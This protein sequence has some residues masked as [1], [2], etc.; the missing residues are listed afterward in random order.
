MRS[1]VHTLALSGIGNDKYTITALYWRMGHNF[2]EAWDSY[3][4]RYDEYKVNFIVRR[5]WRANSPNNRTGDNSNNIGASRATFWAYYDPD[6][7]TAPADNFKFWFHGTGIKEFKG[8]KFN[9]ALKPKA[10]VDGDKY[11]RSG[12]LNVLNNDET[13]WCGAM[14]MYF[15]SA[16]CVDE[17]IFYQDYAYVTLRGKLH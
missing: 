6:G 17:R 11:T 13:K 4:N 2:T 8:S 12:Y 5:W 7:G 16:G 3:K 9:F 1:Q 14:Y 10:L 15:Q